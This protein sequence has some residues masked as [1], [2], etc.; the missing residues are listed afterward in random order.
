[1]IKNGL[2]KEARFLRQWSVG[3]KVSDHLADGSDIEDS[4]V[5]NHTRHVGKMGDEIDLSWNTFG[6]VKDMMEVHK[7]AQAAQ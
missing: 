6:K 2:C 4:Q 5:I 3:F 1:V 7:T